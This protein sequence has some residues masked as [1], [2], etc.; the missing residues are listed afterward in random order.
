MENV[1]VEQVWNRIKEKVMG[2]NMNKNKKVLIVFIN[3]ILVLFVISNTV[4]GTLIDDFKNEIT[5]TGANDLKTNGGKIVGLIQVIGTIAS[6]AMITVIGVK[7]L[8]GS[9]EQK[10]EYRK[11]MTPYFIGA[12]LMFGATNLTQ[13]IYEWANEL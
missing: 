10:A 11:T 1:I 7:Y 9:A 2:G 4:F 12:I 5:T 13:I 6:V 3:L 8:L